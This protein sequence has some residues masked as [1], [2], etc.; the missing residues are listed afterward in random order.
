MCVNE[1]KQY[2]L[3]SK[4]LNPHQKTIREELWLQMVI[5][6][7]YLADVIIEW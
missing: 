5:I 2:N 4:I 6:K 3:V 1:Q 7:Y